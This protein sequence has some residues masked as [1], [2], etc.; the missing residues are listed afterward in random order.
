MAN[1]P[2][3]GRAIR[4]AFLL[5]PD[6][7]YL[8]HGSFGATPRA[9]LA[10]QHQWQNAL[11]REPVLFQEVTRTSALDR[12]LERVGAFVGAPARD[13]VFVTNATT[14]V[15]AVAMS[16]PL[17]PGDEVLTTDH[18]YPAV[19]NTL[20]TLCRRTGATL[21]TVP[22]P[23][24]FADPEQVVEAFRDAI[25]LR[26]RLAVVDHIC[27]GS[28][29]VLPVERL[30]VLC[31]A[32]A[33]P[34]MVDGAHVPGQLP[35]DLLALGP[36]WYTGNLHKWAFAPK[37]CAFLYAAPHRQADLQPP[38]ISW[39]AD[40]WRGAFHW[41]GTTDPSAWLASTAAL[42]FLDSLGPDAV[43]QY[44]HDLARRAACE[45]AEAFGTTLP[46]PPT[47]QAAMVTIRPPGEWS[48]T[49]EEADQL[50]RLLGD[51]YAI[52][53]P[54]FPW[55]GACWVRISAQVYN[56]L[57]DYLRLAQAVREVCR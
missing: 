50:H 37:G 42:D 18:A 47:L 2:P 35:L 14:A 55:G 3:F 22:I 48:G 8:N 24:P 27:S 17:G 36:D 15:N 13:L 54:V 26:T 16:V 41:Q 28:A 51:R 33:V 29:L 52:E 34:L 53:V 44:D 49:Q 40:D 19:K 25:T 11:E 1:P 12:A 38:V 32:R 9:V 43:R 30:V 56:E 6:V 57:E 4:D 46:F 23:V 7:T 10:A 45:L 31:R 21:V 39:E 5:D 20:S